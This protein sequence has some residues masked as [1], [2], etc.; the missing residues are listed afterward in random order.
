MQLA[1]QLVDPDT[2]VRRELLESLADLPV[3]PNAWLFWFSYDPDPLIRQQV[4][5]MMGCSDDPRL[6]RRLR[7][8][9]G[10]ETHDVVRLQLEQIEKL[11][12]RRR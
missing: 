11:Q 6:R 10:I 5:A 7:E 3:S 4:V 1:H 2:R 8:M 12:E 9:Q